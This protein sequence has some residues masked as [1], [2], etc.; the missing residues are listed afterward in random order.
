MSFAFS[1][2]RLTAAGSATLAVTAA[3]VMPAAAQAATPFAYGGSAYGSIVKVGD[4]AETGKSS[5][6]PMCTTVSGRVGT[7]HA[8]GL[9][10]DQIGHLGAVTSRVSSNKTRTGVYSATTTT[11]AG[12]TLLGGLVEAASITTTAKVSHN[13]SG[14]HKTGSTVLV[15]LRVAGVPVS[16]EPGKNTVVAVPGVGTVTMNSQSAYAGGG[17]QSLTV[18]ALRVN[19]LSGNRLGLPAGTAVI[20]YANASL[21]SP[22]HRLPYGS[23]YGTKVDLRGVLKSEPTASV[24]LPCGGSSTTRTNSVASAALG[25]ALHVRAVRSTAKSTDTSTKT[26]A[27]TTNKVAGIDLL[28]GVVHVDAVEARATTTRRGGR[29]SSRSSAG[30]SVVGLSINGVA[31]RVST[32]ENTHIDIAGVGTLYLHRAVRT[33]TGVQVYAV[34]LRLDSAQAGLEAGTVLTVGAARA[35]VL[36]R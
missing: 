25:S 24:A 6:V 32:S 4:L 2:R 18:A 30:T 29:I 33:S 27:A 31:R 15:G 26:V 22:T 7:N 9:D 23:A 12:A 19:L 10:V 17:Y 16:V 36:A 20:G 1:R 5:Y 3:L 28:G 14:Y 21:H 34:Q 11:T 13:S 35:G 8:A